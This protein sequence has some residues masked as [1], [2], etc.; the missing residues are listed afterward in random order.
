MREHRIAPDGM[1]YSSVLSACKDNP[2]L[3]SGWL[4]F[5]ESSRIPT[6]V[7][8]YSNVIHAFSKKCDKLNAERFF[9]RMLDKRIKPDV[10]SFCSLMN[11]YS[12]NGD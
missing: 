6:N 1:S 3:A 7:I 5:M 4:D 8:H 10:F 2:D 9:H 11:A 12:K